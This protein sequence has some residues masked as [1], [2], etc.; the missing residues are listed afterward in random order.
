MN[1]QRRILIGLSGL[2]LVTRGASAASP[3]GDLYLRIASARAKIR[4]LRGPFTQTRRIGLLVSDVRSTGD[5]VMTRP[6][7]LRWR[8]SPPDDVTFWVGP[9]GLAY[10]SAHGQGNV[11]SSSVGVAGALD[12][13]FTLIG[14]DMAKLDRRWLLR[15]VHDTESGIE[16][17]ATARNGSP[18]ATVRTMTFALM[19]DL[20]RPT[21]VVLVEGPHDRT[22]IQFGEL[23]INEPVD[24]V[25]MRPP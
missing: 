14:G 5:L 12:D 9:E 25:E 8:L 10:R 4:T 24:P 1:E 19:A 23:R 7:R 11:P 2:F 20:A 21:R 3:T 13:L 22:D 16:V 18:T 17:E 15:L 6:D